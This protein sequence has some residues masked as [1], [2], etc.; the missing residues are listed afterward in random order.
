MHWTWQGVSYPWPTQGTH[1]TKVRIMDV[2]PSC[3]LGE[4]LDIHSFDW[5]VSVTDS[6]VQR[7]VAR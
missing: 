3:W 4:Y 6:L 1:V 5:V 2:A 7:M